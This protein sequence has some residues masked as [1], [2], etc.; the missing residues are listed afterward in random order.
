MAGSTTAAGEDARTVTAAPARRAHQ[1]D[2]LGQKSASDETDG[3][4]GRLV[5]PLRVVNHADERPL[6]G[7]LRQQPEYSQTD[8]K[9]IRSRV[10]AQPERRRE[11]IALR[12]G[13]ALPAIKQR[14]T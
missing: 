8:D 7:H 3:L 13:Q 1:R 12:G 6:P 4:R 10:R 2:R 14:G 11:R 9:A 5:E